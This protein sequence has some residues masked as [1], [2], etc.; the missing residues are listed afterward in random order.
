M[1]CADAVFVAA[2][3]VRSTATVARAAVIQRLLMN[4]IFI[5]DALSEFLGVESLFF[6]LTSLFPLGGRSE[7]M[8]IGQRLVG[9]AKSGVLGR[10]HLGNLTRSENTDVPIAM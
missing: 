6:L 4:F 7:A 10:G 2:N 8:L 5:G 9:Q 1:K 3:D